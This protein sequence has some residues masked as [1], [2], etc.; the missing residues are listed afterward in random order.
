MTK[1][2]RAECRRLYKKWDRA[3][4][5]RFCKHFALDP[6]DGDYNDE[7]HEPSREW[8]AAFAAGI[9]F[10]RRSTAHHQ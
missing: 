4:Y 10:E 9:A 6:K 5:L 3:G 1:R 8:I 7:P 2:E